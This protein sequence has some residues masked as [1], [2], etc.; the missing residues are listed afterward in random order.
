MLLRQNPSQWRRKVDG[1][2]TNTSSRSCRSLHK[3]THGLKNILD[4][5]RKSLEYCMISRC[6]QIVKRSTPEL[7]IDVLQID[8]Y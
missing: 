2:W 8:I 7:R 6:F 5:G 1:T 3:L 4:A